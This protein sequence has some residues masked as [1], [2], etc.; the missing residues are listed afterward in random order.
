MTI[1]QA[2]DRAES[3][4]CRLVA[5]RLR[6]FETAMLLDGVDV[7]AIDDA[8]ER[9]RGECERAIAAMLDQVRRDLET[10]QAS[11]TPEGVR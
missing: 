4:I 9:N 1:N 10:L 8:I 2:I 5:D 3:L 7:D 11:A 6:E